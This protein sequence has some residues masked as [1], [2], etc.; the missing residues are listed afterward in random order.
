M[1]YSDKDTVLDVLLIQHKENTYK[2]ISAGH[3]N[4]FRIEVDTRALFKYVKNPNL[5][6]FIVVKGD[7]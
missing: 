2:R 7:F 4:Y 1:A 6:E 3:F 5:E